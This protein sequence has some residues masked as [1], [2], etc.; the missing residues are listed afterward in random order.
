MKKLQKQGEDGVTIHCGW[1]PQEI[2]ETNGKVSAIVFKKC[3]SVFNDEGKFAPVYD[4]NTTVTVD[5][6]R[7]IFAIVNVAFGEFIKR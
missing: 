6:E 5:C 3:V 2:I 7:V 4:E 1:G